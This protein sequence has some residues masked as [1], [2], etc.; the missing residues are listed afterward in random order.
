MMG[1]SKSIVLLIS[2]CFLIIGFF[3]SQ[4]IGDAPKIPNIEERWWGPGKPKTESLEIESFKINISNEV[5]F[6]N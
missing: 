2:A 4:Q 5:I 3:I 1:F 6:L